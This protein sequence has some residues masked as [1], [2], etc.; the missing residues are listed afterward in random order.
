MARTFRKIF[1]QDE[2]RQILGERVL[3]AHKQEPDGRSYDITIMPVPGVAKPDDYQ[4]RVEVTEKPN[5][6]GTTGGED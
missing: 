5:V 3:V 4:M 2:L 1:T 6:R